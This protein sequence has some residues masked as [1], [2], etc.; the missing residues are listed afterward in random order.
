MPSGKILN[1]LLQYDS[2][3]TIVLSLALVNQS[4]NGRSPCKGPLTLAIY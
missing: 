3:D 2:L 1:P 4:C